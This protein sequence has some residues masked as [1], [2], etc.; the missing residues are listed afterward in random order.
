MKIC[1]AAGGT[2]GHISPGVSLYKSFKS[3]G[4]ELL[5]ITNPHAL[6][7][8]IIK[9][10]VESQDIITIPISSGFTKNIMKNLKTLLE[11]IKSITISLKSLKSFNPDKIIL[12][13]G[14][15]SAP[16]GI[17]SFL[18]GK[19]AIL[20]EQ[21]SVMGTTNKILSFI[22]K[23]VILSF[24]LEGVKNKRKFIKLGNPIRYSLNDKMMK[25]TAR[26]ILGFNQSDRKLIGI[27]LGSQGAKKVNEFLC[28]NILSILENFDIIWITGEDYYDYV[29][30]KIKNTI[31]NSTDLKSKIQIKIYP[32]ITKMN[33]F[34]SAI[35]IAISRAGA[36]T[37]SEL[38]FFGVPSILIPFPYSAHNHQYYNARYF[39]TKGASVLIKEEELTIESLL[40]AINFILNNFTIF[41]SNTRNIFPQN[42]TDVIADKITKV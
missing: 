30:S 10:E 2:G 19:E 42:V 38:S 31:D 1:I 9:E 11:F 26:N 24:P 17:A 35:D 12:T 3:K 18:L 39:E 27:V 22:A 34:F 32:F 40:D 33:L 15:S 16:I 25:D 28:K 20:L 21:N 4:F 41:S 29:Q 36:S 8:P 14:Y 5:F 7:F 23:N 37:L 6:K 13:G